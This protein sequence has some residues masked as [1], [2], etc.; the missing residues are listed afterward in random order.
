MNVITC[1]EPLDFS[2]PSVFLAGGIV[3]CRDWQADMIAALDGTGC[4]ILNPR[5][6]SFPIHDPKAA[7]EQIE[8]EFNALRRADVISFWFSSETVQPIVMFEY[9]YWLAATSHWWAKKPVLVGCDPEYPRRLDVEHQ[10]RLARE[11]LRIS[12]NLGDLAAQIKRVLSDKP[13]S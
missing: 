13:K 11:D 8:W 6:P 3:G 12:D 1:P 5:R 9:G 2:A 7:P 10:T 4:A